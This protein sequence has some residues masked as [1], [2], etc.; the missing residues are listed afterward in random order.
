VYQGIVRIAKTS[1]VVALQD[2]PRSLQDNSIS[3][4]Q[5]QIIPSSLRESM[6]RA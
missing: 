3:V 4:H 5:P 1:R 2:I 6:I